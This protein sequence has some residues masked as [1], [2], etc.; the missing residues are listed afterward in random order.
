MYVNGATF[1]KFVAPPRCSDFA[2]GAIFIFDNV[3]F[4]EIPTLHVCDDGGDGVID[5]RIG[6]IMGERIVG[7]VVDVRSE[8]GP[9]IVQCQCCEKTGLAKFVAHREHIQQPCFPIRFGS[10]DGAGDIHAN[11]WFIGFSF[12]FAFECVS[13]VASGFSGCGFWIESD[14]SVITRDAAFHA[15]IK[16]E[17]RPERIVPK[18]RVDIEQSRL[19]VFGELY[20]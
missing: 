7:S 16:V 14:G 3:F 2:E 1:L 17:K 12:A 20:A 13:D 19:L 8:F 15:A 11:A 18:T 4:V 5:R 9:I 6:A 10:I